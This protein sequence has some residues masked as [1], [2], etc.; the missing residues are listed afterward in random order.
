MEIGRERRNRAWP[1]AQADG[2][3][4]D[5]RWRPDDRRY[6]KRRSRREEYPGSY[7][8]VES[9]VEGGEIGEAE[10]RH[11]EKRRRRRS[12]SRSPRRYE[13]RSESRGRRRHRDEDPR[14][15]RPEPRWSPERA[16]REYLPPPEYRPYDDD[17]GVSSNSRGGDSN[18]HR[19]QEICRDFMNGRCARGDNC[20]FSHDPSTGLAVGEE[21]GV[22]LA[23]AAAAAAA[24]PGTKM[25]VPASSESDRMAQLFKEAGVTT[26]AEYNQ[27]QK[28]RGVGVARDERAVAPPPPVATQA[29]IDEILPILEPLPESYRQAILAIPGCHQ[30]IDTRHIKTIL[31]L[32]PKHAMAALH[33][34]REAMEDIHSSIRNK[35]GYMMGVLRKYLPGEAASGVTYDGTVV[36]DLEKLLDNDRF[37]DPWKQV[38][39]D[40][41]SRRMAEQ[42]DEEEDRRE[43]EAAK[44]RKSPR[45]PSDMADV[46]RFIRKKVKEAIKTRP[47]FDALHAW[48][49]VENRVAQDSRWDRP[50]TIESLGGSRQHVDGAT[51]AALAFSTCVLPRDLPTLVHVLEK[52]PHAT[53]Y[54]DE[55]TKA[56]HVV[57]RYDAR[58]VLVHERGALAVPFVKPHDRATIVAWRAAPPALAS[59]PGAWLRLR[60]SVTTALVPETDAY[61]RAAVPVHAWL[62]EPLDDDDDDTALPKTRCTTWGVEELPRDAPPWFHK[63][64]VTMAARAAAS[65]STRLSKWLYRDAD[66]ELNDPFP[67]DLPQAWLDQALHDN[68][69][70]HARPDDDPDLLGSSVGKSTRMAAAADGKLVALIGDEDTVTGFLLAGVGH[71]TA[72]KSNFLVVKS[73]TPASVIEHAFNDFT[74]RDDIGIV[75]INQHVANEIRHLLKNYNKTIPTVLE[76]P[77][78]DTPYDPQQDYIMQR[79]SGLLNTDI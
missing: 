51:N 61:D 27:R 21:D 10:R 46:R 53:L 19:H 34:F 38:D 26:I 44:L 79:V 4:G 2:V 24:A 74:N 58:T 13:R 59:R 49:L 76:M 71:R 23:E 69:D 37:A 68:D 12:R 50:D 36:G 35:G 48:D 14:W 43:A 28:A 47:L 40:E 75:L 8:P 9:P 41:A 70:P 6:R 64:A 30:H 18:H 52:P 15:R 20:R 72:D 54:P 1:V 78:K 55:L 7:Q 62:L 25:R 65:F 67:S 31:R 32:N 63:A 66:P 29:E 39:G 42:L 3:D 17:R 22:P 33:E 73:D 45:L 16:R 57:Y 77:S 60:F 5:A 56:H 11:R